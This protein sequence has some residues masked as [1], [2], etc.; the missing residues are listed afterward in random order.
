MQLLLRK[1]SSLQSRMESLE[2][3][4]QQQEQQQQQQQQQ[5]HQ[6]DS[7]H[8][9]RFRSGDCRSL[10][11]HAAA[12]EAAGEAAGEAAAEA[13]EGGGV[14][15]RAAAAGAAAGV[16]R[17]TRH[18]RCRCCCCC[19][20]RCWAPLLVA[21]RRLALGLKELNKE[22]CVVAVVHAL[23]LA[24]LHCFIGYSSS[25]FFSVYHTTAFKALFLGAVVTCELLLLLLLLL[26]F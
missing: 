16:W 23:L 17:R 11:Y 3:L 14:E 5:Q 12:A 25:I 9:G 15:G 8:R 18:H 24:A 1:F 20:Y 6:R 13:A 2:A 19:C 7:R 10:E 4:Q 21:G 26:V 22:F